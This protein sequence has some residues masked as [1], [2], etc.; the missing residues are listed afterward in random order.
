MGADRPEVPSW[1]IAGGV[2]AVILTG[3]CLRSPITSLA[4]VL[5]DIQHELDLSPTVAGLLTSLPVFCLGIGAAVVAGIA[6]RFGLNRVMTLSLLLL[7]VFVAVRP[8]TGA[9]GML[10][11]TAGIGLAITAGNVLLPVVVRRDFPAHQGKVMSAA[12]TS[13]TGGA[14][15]AAILTI[16]IWTAFGWRWAI[17]AWALLMLAAALT[18]HLF[19]G[20]EEVVSQETGPTKVWTIPGAWA[21]ALFFGLNSGLYYASTHWLPTF[22]PEIAGINESQAGVAASILQFAGLIGAISVP[23]LVSKVYN[24]QAFSLAVTSLWLVYTLG[25][26]FAPSLYLVWMIAGAIAQGG[27]FALLLSLYVLRAPNLSMVRDLSG[28]TQT[29]GYFISATAP[30]SVGALFERT[31]SWT[32]G[33]GLLT[34]MAIGLVAITPIV[35][36]RKKL[37]ARG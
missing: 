29:I 21:M 19:A 18:Y 27:V 34:A 5:P 1:R 17:A 11:A 6:R 31:G 10:I 25:L 2:A 32:G 22:L 30:V 36:S 14:A 9:A 12:T 8:F 15:L 28:M 24:R 33:L 35:S 3:L 16:P 26:V 23:V 7:T 20:E 37:Q 4:A 13:I